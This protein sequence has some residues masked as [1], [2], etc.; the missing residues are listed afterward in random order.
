MRFTLKDLKNSRV[1]AALGISPD[2]SR[3][4]AWLN[5]ATER[6]LYT[7]K[8]WGTVARFRM[9]ASDSCLTLPAQIATIE[10]VNI[11]GQPTTVRDFW[12]EFLENGPGSA[13]G[14]P[15]G[16]V[17]NGG[18]VGC[19]DAAIMRGNYPTFSDIHGID[20]KLNF[21]CDLASD[22]CLS[23][24]A[25]GY[26]Q[27]QNWIR[28]LQNGVYKDGEI[29]RLAQ[30]TGTNSVNL[31]SSVT[32]I[33]LPDTLQGQVWLYEYNTTSTTKRMIGHY[34][35]FETNPSYAR[36]YFPGICNRN[37]TDACQMTRVEVMGK[38]AYIPVKQDTDYLIIGNI[39]ALKEMMKAIKKSENEADGVASNRILLSGEAVATKLLDSQLDHH[40]GSGRKMGMTITSTADQMAD[41][42][43]QLL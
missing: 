10:A 4:V 5:E 43:Q 31:F 32:G 25:L 39:P 17:I 6:L 33:Q 18:G 35:Y 23:V 13:E 37:T 16:P 7:G 22:S 14:R 36:Y 19:M 29:I 11:C 3:L 1:P 26:D 20:K 42:I 34:Q 12:Y 9:C 38:L 41:P 24:L 21:I 30:G 8:W 28:T 15:N 40:F 27:N 2:D